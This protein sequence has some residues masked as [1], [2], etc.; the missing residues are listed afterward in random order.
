MRGAQCCF[1]LFRV[2]AARKNEP[3]V[4][5]AF[6]K[7]YETLALLGR[8]NYIFDSWDLGSHEACVRIAHTVRNSWRTLRRDCRSSKVRRRILSA[9]RNLRLA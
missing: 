3:E 8:D 9:V 2:I 1:D 6:R 4:T 5:V 7:R